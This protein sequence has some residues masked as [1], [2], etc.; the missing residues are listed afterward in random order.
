LL[1]GDGGTNGG[2]GAAGVATAAGRCGSRNGAGAHAATISATS[3]GAMRRSRCACAVA[4]VDA[5]LVGCIGDLTRGIYHRRFERARGNPMT[6]YVFAWNPR[7]W[8]WPELPR[9]RRRIETRGSVDIE[10]ACGR[11]RAIEPGSRAFFVRLG[12]PPK[13]LIGSGYALSQ[14]WEDV[15][16]RPEKAAVGATTHYLK[17]RLEFLRDSPIIALDEL[18]VPPFGRFRWAVRQSGMRLPSS[19]AD[20]LEPWWEARVAVA[21]NADAR[22]ART[23]RRR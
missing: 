4:R 3:A 1:D 2:A 20:A 22:R 9:E 15:H 19:I 23:R 6:T 7:L 8:D 13:G 12:V 16:W 11:T 14:P 21:A 5:A 17:L 18:A 10:W